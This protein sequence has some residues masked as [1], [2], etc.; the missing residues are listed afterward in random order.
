MAFDFDLFSGA[1]GSLSRA[2]DQIAE[3]TGIPRGALTGALYRHA[4]IC[5]NKWEAKLWESAHSEKELGKWIWRE[6]KKFDADDETEVLNLSDKIPTL[7]RRNLIEIA[8]SIPAP[9]GGKP[10]KLDLFQR[11]DAQGQFKKLRR[12]GI[13]KEKAYETVARRM[14]VRMHTSVSTHTVRRAC[15]KLER[16]RTR[17]AT[18]HTDFE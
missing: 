12:E 14:S 3:V 7:V 11:W 18:G 16:E 8:K 2:L 9:H 17:K 10:P 4:V 15:D 6:R 5:K 13:S 1:A